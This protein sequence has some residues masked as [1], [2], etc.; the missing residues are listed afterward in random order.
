MVY[1]FPNQ[2]NYNNCN[3]GS[4]N[5]FIIFLSYP[6]FLYHAKAWKKKRTSTKKNRQKNKDRKKQGE[7]NERKN[8][9]RRENKGRENKDI[10][11]TE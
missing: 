9:N 3:K 4:W 5:C 1:N 8:R 7:L 6:I 11:M 10:E 2:N